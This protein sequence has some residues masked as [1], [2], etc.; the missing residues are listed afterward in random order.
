MRTR[1]AEALGLA[2][3]APDPSACG[4]YPIEIV[5]NAATSAAI[6]TGLLARFVK[7]TGWLFYRHLEPKY[8]DKYKEPAGGETRK[9]K[10][11]CAWR[12]S[13]P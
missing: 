10:K 11:A 3:A 2:A 4:A 1:P 13:R 8:P 9:A 6:E 12:L 7:K 5:I